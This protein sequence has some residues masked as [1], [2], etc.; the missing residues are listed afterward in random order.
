VHWIL[1]GTLIAASAATAAY[2]G[3]LMRRLFTLEPGMP[4]TAP[5]PDGSAS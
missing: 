5:A 2:T 4:D 3:Y 1:T